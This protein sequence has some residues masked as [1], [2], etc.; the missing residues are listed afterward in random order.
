MKASQAKVDRARL[1]A[2]VKSAQV[3]ELEGEAEQNAVLSGTL[4]QEDRTSLRIIEAKFEHMATK[5]ELT[6]AVQALENSLGLRGFVWV[7]DGISG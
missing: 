2:K 6:A 4:D 5:A 1:K 7:E 3:S